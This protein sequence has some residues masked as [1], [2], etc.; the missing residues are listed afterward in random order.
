MCVRAD[1][2]VCVCVCA[3]VCHNKE[4]VPG[5]LQARQ[6]QKQV[7]HHQSIPAILT[8][9]KKISSACVRVC[10][11]ACAEKHSPHF[12]CAKAS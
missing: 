10:A 7:T 6:I 2:S 3:S 12:Q 11:C 5:K 4:K 8:E 9:E 1:V